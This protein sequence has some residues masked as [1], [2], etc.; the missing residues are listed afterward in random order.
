MT[1][2]QATDGVLDA[3]ANV[4]RRSPGSGTVTIT[5]ADVDSAGE[6]VVLTDERWSRLLQFC[7]INDEDLTLL[8]D[9][10][11]LAELASAVADSFYEHILGQPDLR[12]IIEHNTSLDRLRATLERY[13]RTFFTG[14]VDDART[15]GVLRIGLVHDRI[16]LPLQSYIGATLRI[17]RVVIPAL[18]SRYQHDPVT[19]G[20]AIMAYRKLF[21][22]DVATVVQTFID[23]R[24][25][26]AML[27]ERLEEQTTQLGDVS[28]TIAAAAEQSHASATN[29]RDLA[30]QMAEQAKAADEL[31]TQTVGAAGEGDAVVEGTERAVADMKRSVEG[32]V[33]ELASLAQQGEDIT[34]IVEVIK[35]I[36]DQ[37][38]LLA[39]NAAIEAA[40]AGEHGRGFAVVAEEVRRLADRTRASLLDITE[41]NDKSLTAIGNVREAVDSTSREAGAV[42]QHTASTRESFG[43]IREAVAQTAT[44]LQSIVTAVDSVAGSSQ[45]LT[46]MSE[47]AARTAERLTEVFNELAGSIEGARDL[48]GEA[49]TKG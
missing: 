49:R 34:R 42:E 31:V 27:V 9:A 25:K 36:A 23:A 35:G 17:D 20:K 43:V 41:L 16:G 8:A 48:V 21:T 1:H 46:H 11:P 4:Q 44:V 30:G 47:D 12:Q 32:I 18:I 19:L 40:R 33:A 28:E 29:M 39:L 7:L 37:T 6:P 45:E 13:F 24:D 14:R 2:H 38:N 26:T 10:A 22:S 15:D 5:A 3:V